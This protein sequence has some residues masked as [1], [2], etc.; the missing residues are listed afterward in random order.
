[1]GEHERLPGGKV[2]R[3]FL[4]IN[5]GLHRVGH[6]DHDDV[7]PGRNFSHR[8][9]GQ[10]AGFGFGARFAAGGQAD[11][12]LNPA[13]LQ[14][15][16]VGVALGAVANNGDF[17]APDECDIGRILMVHLRHDVSLSLDVRV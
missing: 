1:M 11:S 14:V 10:S 15:E 4:L 2:R 6:Q 8:P 3:Y 12:H 5:F 13:V 17:L 16:S 9:H 7:G